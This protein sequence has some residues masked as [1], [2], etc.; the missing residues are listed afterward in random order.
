MEN[1]ERYKRLFRNLGSLIIIGALTVAFAWLWF[2][3]FARNEDLL[4]KVFYRRGNYVLVGMYAVVAFLFYRLF[5]A[6]K[7]GTQRF[8]ESS[9]TQTL[10]VLCTNAF[11][12]L[13]LCL[14][15]HWKFGENIRP[16]L[17]LTLVNVA[18][19]VLWAVI[20]RA[21]YTKLYPPRDVLVVHGH[22]N[23]LGLV[24]KLQSR[25]D[26]Y[27]IRDVVPFDLGLEEIERRALECG[28]VLLLD[29]PAHER[30]EILKYCFRHNVR[31]Y[32][33]PKISDLMVRR[34]EEI[35]FFDTSLLLFRN[36][37]ITAEQQ[38][39]KRVFDVVFSALFLIVASPLMLIIAI[40]IKAY[41][42]G[43]V[44]FTQNRLTR[45]GKV[46]KIYKF[47]S[48]RVADGETEYSMTREHDDRITPV[49]KVIRL[50]HID[51]IPQF[52][53]IFKGEMSVVGPRPECPV[54]AEEYKQ[55][56]PEF[57][58]RLK[59]KAGL[60]GFAQVYG[61]Y[62]TTPLDKLKLDLVYIENY[63]FLLDLKLIL[64]TIKVLFQKDSTQGIA[65]NRTSAAT[66]DNLAAVGKGPGHE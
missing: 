57:D 28:S 37:G 54:L 30:N 24:R 2:V 26:K 60:T 49:G 45:D 7:L 41:D 32:C 31:C 16:F 50:L 15:G 36:A 52:I 27:N 46:F 23:P 56:I 19:A 33:V 53:N 38:A 35:H 29:I 5:G 55:M 13:E 47:R 43:P 39:F 42:G 61:K 40:C 1:R 66:D 34:S 63:S 4:V 11:T 64:L 48:M 22:Y 20:S 8:M 58:L 65:D 18:M 3:Y 44:F 17:Y 59:M 12:Y 10:A 25:R 6:L 9:F 21:I 14:I 62:N 51:E